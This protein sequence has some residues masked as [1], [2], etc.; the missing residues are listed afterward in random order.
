MHIILAIGFMV[1]LVMGL[2]SPYLVIWLINSLF[3]CHTPYN[4]ESWLAVV[5][6]AFLLSLIVGGDSR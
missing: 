3:N 5:I 6:G 4:L 1:L 2:M